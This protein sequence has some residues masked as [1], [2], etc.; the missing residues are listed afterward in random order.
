MTVGLSALLT[1]AVGNDA[2]AAR[3]KAA[4]TAIETPAATSGEWD[5]STVAA[6]PEPAGD[7][8]SQRVVLGKG[9]TIYGTLVRQGV[10][11]DDVAAATRAMGDRFDARR[12]KP[13]DAVVVRRDTETRGTAPQRMTALHIE[14]P[15]RHA[16]AVVRGTDGRFS[17]SAEAGRGGQNL[18][19]RTITLSGDIDRSLTGSGLPAGVV[20]ELQAAA[21]VD[22]GFPTKIQK[23]SALTVVFE[24]DGRGQQAEPTL[25]FASLQS[26][27]REHRLYRF[28]LGASEVAYVDETGRGMARVS[29]DAPIETGEVSSGWGWRVHPVL[30]VKRFHR[31]VDFRAPRG[32]PALAA[33]DGVVEDIGRRGNYG[34]YLRIRHGSTLSTAYAHLDGFARGLS[35]GSKI[36]KGQTVGY[37]GTTGLATGPH[38]YYEVMVSDRHVNPLE[39]DGVA[40]PVQLSDR[41]LARF[42]SYV[43][44]TRRQIMQD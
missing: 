16:M 23:G 3:G 24:E 18:H 41:D 10:S 7:E 1:V 4:R 20:R 35:K 25:R 32:T 44:S 17:K 22:P 29:L 11:P 6:P 9:D 5:M 39:T 28:A 26:G 21:E 13:G 34:L 30:K 42:R 8:A 19:R 38:L 31:G 12:V 43:E 37:V 27:A 2:L 36:R 33:A 40:V 14:V 15:D